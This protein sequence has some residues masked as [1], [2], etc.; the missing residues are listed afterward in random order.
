VSTQ[1]DRAASWVAIIGG[2]VAVVTTDLLTEYLN[3]A[4]SLALWGIACVA[5]FVV[6]FFVGLLSLRRWQFGAVLVAIGISVGVIVDAVIQ[7]G[8]RGHGRNLW[9]FAIIF[10]LGLAVPS[11]GLGLLIGRT[12]ARKRRAGSLDR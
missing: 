1:Q 11:A 5:F 12:A 6:A 2:I 8:F 10:F 3:L 7:E 9:P 4:D